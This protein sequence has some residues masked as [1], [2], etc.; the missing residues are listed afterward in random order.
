MQ[1]TIKKIR[2]VLLTGLI[3]LNPVQTL[4]A[5]D[6]V[7]ADDL[8]GNG[9]VLGSGENAHCSVI[10]AQLF[11]GVGAQ[12]CVL[13]QTLKQYECRENGV[14][15]NTQTNC[16]N[17]CN[18]LDEQIHPTYRFVQHRAFGPHFTHQINSLK[19]C[20]RSSS[21]W[22]CI[23]ISHGWD[24][25]P[26]THEGVE[27]KPGQ[28]LGRFGWHRLY[29]AIFTSTTPAACNVIE[30][31]NPDP[32]YICPTLG[33]ACVNVGGI[34][35]CSVNPCVDL[36][37]LE[38][39]SI[40]TPPELEPATVDNGNRDENGVCTNRVLLFNGKPMRCRYKGWF[41]LA[42][43]CCQSSGQVLRDSTGGYLTTLTTSVA[44]SASWEV[45]S[46]GYNA[47]TAEMAIAN[48]AGVE[49]A[50]TQAQWAAQGALESF[51][52]DPTTIAISLAI[53]VFMSMMGCEQAEQEAAIY[54]GSGYCH[55]VGSFCS[56]KVVL[57]GCVEKS[58][59]MCC[60]NSKLA[61][62]IQQQGREQLGVDWGNPKSPSCGGFSPEQFQA[63]DFNQ[64]D[65]S[66]YYGDI[67]TRGESLIQE[68]VTKHVENY[69]NKI[70]P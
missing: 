15:Y 5:T 2:L 48:G 14:R 17:H 1:I 33:S 65:M 20:Y 16:N 42:D 27:Y 68:G 53:K 30:V 11:C 40:T 22:N 3:C 58:K 41:G 24:L 52:I 36:D 54:K 34:Q 26:F 7:C 51:T 61:R 38:D 21:S 10:N 18:S 49:F 8:D 66:E 50:A 62:I 37:S 43:N 57:L 29:E 28:Y 6:F 31:P 9:D 25:H 44:L 56:K 69:Y 35:Q 47:F 59:G 13:E 60:F 63:L 19:F 64:I 12:D 45:L 46:A 23:D 67:K 32:Q 39:A 4:Q 55:E 70:S